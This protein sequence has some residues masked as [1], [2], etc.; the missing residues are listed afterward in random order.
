MAISDYAGLQTAITTWLAR[1]TLSIYTPDFIRLFE[2]KFNRTVRVREMEEF[3][4]LTV[5]ANGEVALPS[6]YLETRRLIFVGDSKIPLDYLSPNEFRWRY[7]TISQGFPA[8][9]TIEGSTI[10]TAP[11]G[12]GTLNLLYYARLPALETTDTN[13]L[14]QKH[15]DIY[16]FGSLVEAQAFGQNIQGVQGWMSRLDQAMQELRDLDG[17]SRFPSAMPVSVDQTP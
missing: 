14:L 9:Y 5:D 2:A 15:P 7:P 12:S 10:A 11:L 8:N 13:W 3:T 6:D 4:P 16:L 17:E 1:T